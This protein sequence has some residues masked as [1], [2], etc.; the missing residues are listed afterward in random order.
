MATITVYFIERVV[1]VHGL[2]RLKYAG[3]HLEYLEEQMH[4]TRKSP[5]SDPTDPF[6]NDEY[7]EDRDWVDWDAVNHH[8]Y[9]KIMKQR[10]K[11]YE[12]MQAYAQKL[13][14]EYPEYVQ[15]TAKDLI[16][17]V[18]DNHPLR[19]EDVMHEHLRDIER[20]FITWDHFNKSNG[21]ELP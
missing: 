14:E 1:F 6:L 13:A 12:A 7:D 16:K 5:C 2:N 10:F 18:Y 4:L 17:E 3:K 11:W 15:G 21:Y 20:K 8:T 9:M 19:T